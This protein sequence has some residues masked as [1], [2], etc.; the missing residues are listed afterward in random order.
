M[1][2]GGVEPQE[3]SIHD[4]SGNGLVY[5]GES[6]FR[7]RRYGFVQDCAIGDF[8]QDGLPDFFLPRAPAEMD[9]H[10][11]IL[12][13][14][15]DGLRGILNLIPRY[16]TNGIAQQRARTDGPLTIDLASKRPERWAREVFIGGEGVQPESIPFV[17][18]PADPHVQGVIE[19]EDTSVSAFYIGLD[20]SGEWV[21][22]MTGNS[23][24]AKAIVLRSESPI[25]GGV[26]A[27]ETNMLYT[28]SLEDG[29]SRWVSPTR[30]ILL[31]STPD[32][33]I[34]SAET[35]GVALPTYC[36]SAVA[37]DFDNDMDMD[38]FLACGLRTANLENVLYLNE[39]EGHFR[40][41][42][43]AGGATAG[44][45]GPQFFEFGFGQ[46]VAIA[47][48]NNDGF[49]D[50]YVSSTHLAT[51]SVSNVSTPPRLYRNVGNE[52]HWLQIRLE[53]TQSN[54]DGI[55]A[56]VSVETRDGTLQ[57]REQDGGSHH[58]GQNSRRLHFGLGH[59]D[60]GVQVTVHWPSGE[61]QTL[62]RVRVD[63]I[64]QIT[65]PEA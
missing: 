1:I 12:I 44:I 30:D 52:N 21:F 56:R 60:R 5:D 27:E 7:S 34:D 9:T 47:D 19:P 22:Q 50:I 20:E 57:F 10:E 36:S 28:M 55:G 37:A 32:G 18:N 62:R 16:G 38:L 33:Y 26:W 42:Y 17:L 64:I 31:L 25:T 49:V 6:P 59:H 61:V 14:S 3:N 2:Y 39:G 46:R 45:T 23:V 41:V 43:G 13:V 11:R 40:R 48:Y 29:P 51:E 54:R 63:R 24:A 4:G 58:W 53:G 35:H 15:D 8:N 65:E